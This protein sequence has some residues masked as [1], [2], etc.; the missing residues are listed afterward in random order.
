M[1]D[2]YAVSAHRAAAEDLARRLGIP[3]DQ[4][5]ERA[6]MAYAAMHAPQGAQLPPAS[7]AA[8]PLF[9]GLP[10]ERV[11]DAIQK[12]VV[13]LDTEGQIAYWNDRAEVLY[14]WERK[15]V[16]S[17]SIRELVPEL[18]GQLIDATPALITNHSWV[19]EMPVHHRDGAV[20]AVRT[21]ASR[22][23]GEDGRTL[24]YVAVMRDVSPEQRS[25]DRLAAEH[26]VAEILAESRS[27]EEA[28][29]RVLAA[30]CEKLDFEFGEFWLPE[31]DEHYLTRVAAYSSPDMEW[32]DEQ[33]NL[34]QYGRLALADSM[35]GHAWRAKTPVWITDIADEPFLTRSAAAARSGLHTTILV[36]ALHGDRPLTALVFLTRR[37]LDPDPDVLGMF[38]AVGQVLAQFVERTRAEAALRENALTLQHALAAAQ[39]GTWEIDLRT[40][41]VRR[42]ASTDALFGFPPA[43]DATEERSLDEYLARIH[44]EEVESVIAALARSREDGRLRMEVRILP[45]P[46]DVRWTIWRGEVVY[47]DDGQPARLRGSLVDI[48]RRREMEE[49]LREL[50]ETLELRVAERTAELE[51][52]NQELDQFAY[53]ASHDLRAPLRAIHTLAS[54]IRE[55]SGLILPPPSQEHLVKL[56]AR[57]QRME[58]LLD[59]LL[60][61]SRAGRFR[62]TPE[63]VDTGELTRNVVELLAPPAGF[64]VEIGPAMPTILTERV[65]LET[66]LRNLIGNSIKHHHAPAQG[67]LR[68]SALIT[69]PAGEW[70]EFTVAD[71]GPGIAPEF[72]AR[73]FGMFQ[74]LRPRDQVEGS[75]VGLAIVK[76]MV[77]S[78]GGQVSV[79][80]QTGHGAKFC[81]TWPVHPAADAVAP[82]AP[83]ARAEAT[84]LE[85]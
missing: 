41:T 46:G 83:E 80:S 52:S 84:E 43:T 44:P 13:V 18:G 33:A 85:S 67:C 21:T 49:Q 59:D 4:L 55:D 77:E 31:A 75:G 38:A 78:R 2:T 24:G 3:L 66:V 69:L 63:T 74:T 7:P 53:I 8:T 19:G 29:P 65:P 37:R 39:M 47:D 68:V 28:A 56:Q 54:W 17:R 1:T 5:Y 23:A 60:D 45:E 82:G 50:N 40:Y 10:V 26:A 30:I 76:K 6:V 27:F 51:R 62:H 14:G 22:I 64:A 79:A 32:R 81:F 9:A 36:P 12:A 71:D 72:H 25:R 58:R 42:S 20:F 11:L 35:P 48:S 73:I 16:L 57:A 34:M 15:E 61:Y 70:V